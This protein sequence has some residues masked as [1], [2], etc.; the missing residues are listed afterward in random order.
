M[1]NTDQ[2]RPPFKISG[3]AWDG[4]EY[5]L[6]ALRH[7]VAYLEKEHALIAARHLFGMKG[8]EL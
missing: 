5:D 2:S 3:V 1:K 7:R 8:G 6:A 4:D